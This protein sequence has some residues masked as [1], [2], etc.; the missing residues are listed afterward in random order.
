MLESAHSIE[1]G[2]QSVTC[3]NCG[4]VEFRLY[5]VENGFNLVKCAGCGL[6]YVNPRPTDELINEATM[7]GLHRGRETYDATD[8]FDPSQVDRYSR[9]LRDFYG[10]A[11]DFGDGDWLDIGCGYGEFMIALKR[12]SRNRARVRGFEPNRTKAEVARGMGLEVDSVDLSGHRGK[13]PFISALN[14]YSH[15]PNPVEGLK[16]WRRLLE[17]GGELLLETGHS[18]H[19]DRKDHHR[20]YYLPDHLSFANRKIVVG[21]LEKVGFEVLSVKIYR[22][23]MYPQLRLVSMLKA[24]ARLALGRDTNLNY[25]PRFPNREMWIRARLANS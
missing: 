9:I 14:V 19:L 21:I 24:A 5:D 6:L 20:P 4:S 16:D 15:L 1:S 12:F 25:F 18:C 11:F 8:R 7:A 13:Y 10:V 3:Y 17:P 23:V 22:A 2:V